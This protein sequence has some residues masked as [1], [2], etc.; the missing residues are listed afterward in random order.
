MHAVGDGV[1]GRD[2]DIP[3]PGRFEAFPVLR[4][5]QGPGDAADV[6]AAFGA[7]SGGEAV[8]GDDVRAEVEDAVAIGRAFSDTFAG[9]APAS[10]LPFIAAQLAGAAF[11]LTITVL[12]YGGA[13][14][15]GATAAVLVPAPAP[16]PAPVPAPV[17][18][19]EPE[20]ATS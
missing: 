12:L 6:V 4:E 11:G 1:G 5:G 20:S 15:V 10:V 16:A 17:P 13:A 18:E 19:G 3:E 14:P 2:P 9:I 8:V 7:L